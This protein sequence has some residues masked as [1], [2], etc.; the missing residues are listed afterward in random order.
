MGGGADG[1]VQLS[2]RR[3]LAARLRPPP[4]LRSGNQRSANPAAARVGHDEPPLEIGHAV[5]VTPLCMRPDGEFREAHRL[6]G[7]IF[8]EEDRE[9]VRSL[10]SEE[11]IDLLAVLGCGALRPEG[12]P[13][14]EP[15]GGV[16][17]RR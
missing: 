2:I 12:V 13:Q 15:R 9:W 11:S 3:E 6:P 8:G 7:R 1:V 17:S 14:A 5:G 4:L 10:A 16:A